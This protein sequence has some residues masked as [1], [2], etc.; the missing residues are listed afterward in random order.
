VQITKKAGKGKKTI[1]DTT[2]PLKT[3]KP[4]VVVGPAIEGGTLLLIFTG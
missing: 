1:L 3:G 4:V 2:I